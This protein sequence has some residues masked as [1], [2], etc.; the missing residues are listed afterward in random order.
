M[1][2]FQTLLCI[3]VLPRI[4][5]TFVKLSV[6]DG[7]WAVY[8][9]LREICDAILAPV[10]EPD[11]LKDLQ[12]MIAEFLRTFVEIFGAEKLLPKFH[13]LLHYPRQIALFG[14]LKILWCMRFEA[15]H[16]YF[17]KLAVTANNNK[18]LCYTLAKRHQSDCVVRCQ[19][20]TFFRRRKMDAVLRPMLLVF[21][22]QI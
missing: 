14:P 22:V 17:K 13:Y 20:M 6:S 21:C 10:V 2:V 7:V 5:A 8:L 9:A 11:Q 15:K 16:Q 18:N 4:L 19:Q 1:K 12:H 3:A